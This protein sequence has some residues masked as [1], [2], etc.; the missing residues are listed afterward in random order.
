MLASAKAVLKLL[1]EPVE[2]SW[3][4]PEVL[5]ITG[6]IAELSGDL[7]TAEAKYLAAL[8]LAERQ[9]ALAWRIRAATSLASLWLDQGRAAEAHATLA[10]VYEQFGP[11]RLGPGRRR[12]AECLETCR[13]ALSVAAGK[14]KA[15]L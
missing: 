9:N 14:E 7:V 1:G 3:I 12:A 4:S 6:V 5:R 13:R 8:E 10:P 2:E 15:V 11:G